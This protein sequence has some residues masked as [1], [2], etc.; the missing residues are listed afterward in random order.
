[1]CLIFLRGFRLTLLPKLLY[2]LS[3]FLMLLGLICDTSL[4]IFKA[5]GLNFYFNLTKYFCF[6]QRFLIYI[7]AE[8]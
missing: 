8:I 7:L 2:C 3:I 4:I 5:F 1:M 6:F